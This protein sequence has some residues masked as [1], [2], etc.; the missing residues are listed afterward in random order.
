[1]SFAVPSVQ[2]PSA[3]RAPGGAAIRIRKP[4]PRVPCKACSDPISIKTDSGL[5]RS[6]ARKSQAPSTVPL[7]RNCSDCGTPISE[8]SKGRCK[9]CATT[10][11][12]RL[13]ETKAKRV[14]GWKKRLSDPVKY[15]QVCRTA[16]RNSQ[17]AM[18]DPVKRA[19]AQE[20]A[21]EVYRLYLDT[22]EC[23]A[24]VR[25]SRKIAGEKVRETRLAWCPPEY[26]ELHAENV[27]RHRMRAAQ[28]RELIER[29]MA[30]DRALKDV[31]SALDYL[32]K[33]APVAKLENGF[34]Y[35]NAILTPAEII[36]R[37]TVRGWERMAA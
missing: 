18:A 29:L 34:R 10:Y 32:L 9:S 31:D 33:F 6:C 15:E 16:T 35:G 19:A 30:N 21:R 12:N 20:R 36:S 11:Y 24:K 1:M 5:C 22:P 2:P 37:A 14:E 28:S 8:Q 17:K 23:R 26:R 7:T 25:A 4:I 13:P 27:N 3:I